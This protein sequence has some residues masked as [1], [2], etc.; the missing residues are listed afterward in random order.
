MYAL[1]QS[2]QS[3]PTCVHWVY[4]I[5][6]NKSCTMENDASVQVHAY[7]WDAHMTRLGLGTA[8]RNARLKSEWKNRKQKSGNS[9]DIRLTTERKV[10]KQP[11]AAN[12]NFMEEYTF[13][14]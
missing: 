7:N 2:L 13:G 5:E 9:R 12:A 8:A 6:E 1:M 11:N 10:L 14:S 4:L 3:P